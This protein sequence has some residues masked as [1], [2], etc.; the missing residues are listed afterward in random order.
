MSSTTP[1]PQEPAQEIGGNSLERLTDQGDREHA[2]SMLALVRDAEADDANVA[3]YLAE[4]AEKDDVALADDFTNFT[5]LV[6]LSGADIGLDWIHV[7]PSEPFSGQGYN[8]D[9]GMV[10]M[11]ENLA[12][13]LTLAQAQLVEKAIA[14][15]MKPDRAIEWAKD[16][17]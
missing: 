17:E 7:T 4:Q 6:P 12:T 15:G 2:E 8:V 13:V 1:D 10:P 9:Y 5:G 16:Q 11:A 14:S 3:E